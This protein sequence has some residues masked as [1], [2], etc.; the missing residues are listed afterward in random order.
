M[1]NFVK[2]VYSHN[3]RDNYETYDSM[4]IPEPARG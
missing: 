4:T 3:S 1:D 2:D